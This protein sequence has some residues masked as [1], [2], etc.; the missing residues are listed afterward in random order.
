MG[1][2]SVFE[3]LKTLFELQKIKFQNLLEHQK[4]T[5]FTVS[6]CMCIHTYVDAINL[7][8]LILN[9]F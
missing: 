6:V 1:N 7:S 3:K 4:I 9:N 8:F 2:F 5:T